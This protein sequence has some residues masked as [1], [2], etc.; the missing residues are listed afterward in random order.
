MDL[1]KFFFCRCQWQQHS[2]FRVRQCLLL[3]LENVAEP[4]VTQC[5]PTELMQLYKCMLRQHFQ[6]PSE[7]SPFQQWYRLSCVVILLRKY[8]PGDRHIARP[9]VT[10][11]T[12]NQLEIIIGQS[13]GNP[14]QETTLHAC[15]LHCCCGTPHPSVS[16]ARESILS[17]AISDSICLC[18]TQAHGMVV[19]GTEKG[20]V[21]L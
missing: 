14:S 21:L 13:I 4:F 20:Q 10:G 2:P 1:S 17:H 5:C 12:R 15:T 16:T 9:F 19:E 3:T 18:T 6:V 7:N 8:N 11:V